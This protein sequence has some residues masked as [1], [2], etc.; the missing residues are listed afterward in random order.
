MS[1]LSCHIKYAHVNTVQ[2]SSVQAEILLRVGIFLAIKKFM[3][4]SYLVDKNNLTFYKYIFPVYPIVE[5][6]GHHNLGLHIQLKYA[7]Q[8]QKLQKEHNTLTFEKILKT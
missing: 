4:L 3:S 2:F 8:I 5:T 1:C 7:M 6:Y